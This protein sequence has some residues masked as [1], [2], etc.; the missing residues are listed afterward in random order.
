MELHRSGNGGT[1]MEAAGTNLA[2]LAGVDDGEGLRAVVA[3]Q[4]GAQVLGGPRGHVVHGSQV[5]QGS[6]AA[7]AAAQRVPQGRGLERLSE[8]ALAAVPQAGVGQGALALGG[9]QRAQ[10][11][12]GRERRG[13]LGGHVARAQP[14]VGPAQ[15]LGGGHG[16]SQQR[17][18]QA[19]HGQ[20][21]CWRGH[22]PEAG[23]AG[24]AG[25]L[26]RLGQGPLCNLPQDGGLR[27]RTRTELS[28]S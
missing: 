24:A 2:V 26:L 27:T 1:G 14:R 9:R 19:A 15:L 18:Q 22:S 12:G 10:G 7:R 25:R 13:G 23:A 5:L 16:G 8:R 21:S 20:R 4:D 3:R 6:L 17:Q 11:P 28:C